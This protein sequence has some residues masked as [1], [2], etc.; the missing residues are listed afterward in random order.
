[1]CRKSGDKGNSRRF[2][3]GLKKRSVLAAVERKIDMKGRQRKERKT[4][5]V[6][7]GGERK[8][9]DGTAGESEK[10]NMSHNVAKRERESATKDIA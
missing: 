2:L 7:R 10:M 5:T 9:R 4:A 1:M 6:R 3:R 8:D